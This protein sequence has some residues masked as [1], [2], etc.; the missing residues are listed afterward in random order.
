MNSVNFVAG[1]CGW[2]LSSSWPRP[3]LCQLYDWALWALWLG[4]APEL[5][6]LCGWAQWLGLVLTC[7]PFGRA[8]ELCQLC[9]WALWPR[10]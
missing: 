4:R 8:P 5:C 7:P 6:Q 3:Q 9:G 10:P 2:A 1:L